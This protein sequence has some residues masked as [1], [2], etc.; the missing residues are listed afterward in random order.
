ML[1]IGAPTNFDHHI[2]V[3][4]ITAQAPE[5]LPD[6]ALHLRS[7]NRTRNGMSADNDT[8]PWRVIRRVVPEQEG[9]IDALAPG[10]EATGKVRRTAQPRLPR[11]F[12]ARAAHTAKRARP[13]ARRALIT[14]RPP[15]V[16]MRTR[17]PCVRARRVLDG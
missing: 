8:Q 14:A 13:L 1:P 15:R 10:R 3:T 2:H 9:E 11:Q 7:C 6:G 4:E 5:N 16:F 12:G 17:K